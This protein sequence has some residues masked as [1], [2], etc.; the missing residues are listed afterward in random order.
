MIHNRAKLLNWTQNG[1][2]IVNKKI[3]PKMSILR[4]VSALLSLKEKGGSGSEDKSDR[5]MG[6]N[7]EG[8]TKEVAIPMG[9]L[10]GTH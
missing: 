9:G 2:L 8:E 6:I 4:I 1:E 3:S 10:Q 5:T 7:V